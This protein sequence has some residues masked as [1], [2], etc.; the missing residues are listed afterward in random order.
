MSGLPRPPC[1]RS[2]GAGTPHPRPRLESVLPAF[3][4]A[5]S[6]QTQVYSCRPEEIQQSHLSNTHN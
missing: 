4:V 5:V 1:T 3:L 2:E 6:I